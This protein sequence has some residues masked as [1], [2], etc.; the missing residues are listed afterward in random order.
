M[1]VKVLLDLP[2]MSAFMR[3]IGLRTLSNWDT[4]SEL[5]SRS[6]IISFRRHA[7]Q[8]ITTCMSGGLKT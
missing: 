6:S 8:T 2:S 3:E 4:I 5:K 1:I 7:F